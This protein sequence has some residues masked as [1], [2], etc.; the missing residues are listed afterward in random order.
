MGM[1]TVKG[2]VKDDYN[3]VVRPGYYEL[4][5]ASVV[6]G[7]DVKVKKVVTYARDFMLQAFKGENIVAAGILEKA[8]PLKGGEEYYR[9][10]IGY[11]ESYTTR[12]GEE[13]IKVQR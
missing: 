13:Y 10:V 8:T 11:F 6:Q 7:P 2:K 3:G 5:N 9:I 1:A 12:R 4:E